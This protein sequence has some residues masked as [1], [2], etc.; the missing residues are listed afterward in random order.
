MIPEA[1]RTRPWVYPRPV[2]VRREEPAD[3]AGIDRVHRLA[4]GQADEAEIVARLRGSDAFI[5]ELSI[6]AEDEGEVLGHILFT[7]VVLAPPT[8]VRVLS[9]APMAVLPPH[10]RQ[11]IGSELV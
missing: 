5:P 2:N 9:L 8:N 4:F 6:V 10:Q 11:G 7:R 1:R 3:V